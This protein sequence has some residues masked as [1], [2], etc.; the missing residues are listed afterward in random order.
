[1]SSQVALAESTQSGYLGAATEPGDAGPISSALAQFR[2]A[3][4]PLLHA[5]PA[6]V[7]G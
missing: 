5:S 7:P 6:K 4:I 3:I 1:V 2:D